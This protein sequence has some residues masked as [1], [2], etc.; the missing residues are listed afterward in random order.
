MAIVLLVIGYY[1]DKYILIY[2]AIIVRQWG[3]SSAVGNVTIF[4][5]IV[6]GEA[7]KFR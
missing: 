6:L 1:I 2:L 4:V 3:F 7:R 5:T